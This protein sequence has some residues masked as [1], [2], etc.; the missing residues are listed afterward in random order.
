MFCGVSPVGNIGGLMGIFLG[1]S[2]LS[3]VELMEFLVLTLM[4]RS[5]LKTGDVSDAENGTVTAPGDRAVAVIKER[6][7]MINVKTN[8]RNLKKKKEPETV[9]IFLQRHLT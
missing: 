1:A 7:R 2:L 8:I 6:R 5:K 3:V 9:L 4:P